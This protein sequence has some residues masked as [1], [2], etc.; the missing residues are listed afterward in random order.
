VIEAWIEH[1]GYPPTVR[2]IGAAVGLGSPSSVVLSDRLMS[3][4]RT[5]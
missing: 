2:E 1:Y 5:E 3:A 4:V